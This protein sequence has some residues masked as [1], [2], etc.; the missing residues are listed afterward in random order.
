MGVAFAATGH[1]AIEMLGSSASVLFTG[2]RALWCTQGQ[3]GGP[4]P[5]TCK[6]GSGT[7][8]TTA[9]RRRWWC[10]LNTRRT[11]SNEGR[12]CARKW[13]IIM[14]QIWSLASSACSCWYH[15]ISHSYAARSRASWCHG[16]I[17]HRSTSHRRGPNC[18]WIHS[19]LCK[20]A[21]HTRTQTKK[22]HRRI[23]RRS[24]ARGSNENLQSPAEQ[25]HSAAPHTLHNREQPEAAVCEEKNPLLKGGGGGLECFF[26]RHADA[27][28]VAGSVSTTSTH[29]LRLHIVQ[30]RGL[31]HSAA[32][33]EAP[34]SGAMVVYAKE[35]RIGCERQR[36][37]ESGT[38]QKALI[39]T[40]RS[41]KITGWQ[42]KVG[43]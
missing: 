31:T 37:E 13:T 20:Q 26:C 28:H 35:H 32:G 14:V 41:K 1:H 36:E 43:Q 23:C 25:R 22:T 2:N 3:W 7:T 17:A 39:A 12:K 15:A 21:R 38:N 18:L 9:C 19:S 29:H 8:T 33:G 10:P 6:A 27:R 40:L 24:L 5:A 16:I 11:I 42:I 4:C 34:W 30:R